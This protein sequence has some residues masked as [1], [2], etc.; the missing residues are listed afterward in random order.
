[1]IGGG[2]SGGLN[3]GGGEGM[4]GGGGGEAGGRGLVGCCGGK[5]TA[6][7]GGGGGREAAGS[8]APLPN[9][10][11]SSDRAPSGNVPG[12]NVYISCKAV[13]VMTTQPSA[14]SIPSQQRR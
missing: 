10:R 11:S 2:G 14:H 12:K 5:S 13:T 4:G 7:N 8:E 6:G 3:G 9:K 1:M